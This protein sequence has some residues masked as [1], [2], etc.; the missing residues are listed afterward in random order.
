M[1]NNADALCDTVFDICKLMFIVFTN[2]LLYSLNEDINIK[3]IK[4]IK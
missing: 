4:N 2:V 3:D 1:R